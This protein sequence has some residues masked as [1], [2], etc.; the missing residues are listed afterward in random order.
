MGC[1]DIYCSRCGLPIRKIH[2]KNKIIPDDIQ[3]MLVK[4]VFV[5]DNKYMLVK[6]CDDYG[7]CKDSSGN[8]IDVGNILYSSNVKSDLYHISCYRY[9]IL[10][11]NKDM[12]VK[13]CNK[14]EFDD[15]EYIKLVFLSNRTGT[16]S[17]LI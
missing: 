15:E 17:T 6:D 11:N 14:Q 4:A 8:V 13:M 7:R 9:D 5:M 16:T 1:Y 12:V 10:K 2:D 3:N